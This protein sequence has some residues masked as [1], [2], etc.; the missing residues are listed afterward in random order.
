MVRLS[1]G[2]RTSFVDESRQPSTSVKLSV[3]METVLSVT[4]SRTVREMDRKEGPPVLSNSNSTHQPTQLSL[5]SYVTSK[6]GTGVGVGGGV[7]IGRAAKFPVKVAYS[8]HNQQYSLFRS[9]LRMYQYFPVGSRPITSATSPTSSA[10]TRPYAL[11]GPTRQLVAVDTL[12]CG[13]RGVV[14]KI[15]VGDNVAVGVKVGNS[16]VKVA[17]GDSS[18]R[19]TG[20]AAPAVCVK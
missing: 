16:G 2:F 7:Y 15:G 8:P 10:P 13:T 9:G 1:P 4:V 20:T 17:V 5:P 18:T 19:P 11:P 14:V 12:I 6:A 3:Y